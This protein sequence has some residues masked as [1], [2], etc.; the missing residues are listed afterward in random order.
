MRRLIK[1][2]KYLIT[3]N[4]TSDLERSTI[5]VSVTMS[6]PTNQLPF[7]ESNTIAQANSSYFC[8]WA[9]LLQTSSISRWSRKKAEEMK[10]PSSSPQTTLLPPKHWSLDLVQQ[11]N[12]SEE[13]GWWGCWCWQH[14]LHLHSRIL[15]HQPDQGGITWELC[16]VIWS[17]GYPHD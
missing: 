6:N 11:N 14:Q 2:T 8:L 3:C 17:Q 10:V 15:L 7:F 4:L 5:Y 9:V 12:Y 13:Q 16:H 1:P